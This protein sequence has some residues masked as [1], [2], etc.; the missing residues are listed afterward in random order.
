MYSLV[1]PVLFQFDAETANNSV[2]KILRLTGSAG[3]MMA[4][5]AYG[6]PDKRLAT[7]LAGMELTGPVGLA[8]VLDKNGV[9]ARFWPGLGFGFIEMGTVTAHA[10]SGNPKPRMFR[11]P[12]HGA[13]V[14]RM[15]FNNEGSEVLA[16]RLVE[17]GSRDKSVG[18]P[19][20]NLPCARLSE[21]QKNVSRPVQSRAGNKPI[22]CAP[23]PLYP[24]QFVHK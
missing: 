13:L 20:L 7:H 22:A 19:A 9:L 8:A 14:N 11:F 15:G 17:L 18:V 21:F 4:T 12:S 23:G 6:K 16:Q 1:R 2:F 10:Q 3:R 24:R 5:I